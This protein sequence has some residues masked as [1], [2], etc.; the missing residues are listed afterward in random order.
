MVVSMAIRKV[1]CI[2]PGPI[3]T[4][5][6]KIDYWKPDGRIRKSIEFAT[7]EG[8]VEDGYVRDRDSYLYT[9]KREMKAG[10]FKKGFL[11]FT[12]NSS[13]VLSR[14]VTLPLVSYRML[15]G[16]IESGN[17]NP[18]I[19]LCIDIC[20]ALNRTLDELFWPVE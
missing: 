6:S 20:K 1:V 8:A 15:P 12:L 16:L 9:L 3:S 4:R 19:S 13:R 10:K 5:I 18:S 11:V 2:E 14:E 17:Y 7:P